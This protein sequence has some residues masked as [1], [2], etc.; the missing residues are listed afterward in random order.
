MLSAIYDFVFNFNRILIFLVAYAA[1]CF[2]RNYQNNL[3][4]FPGEGEDPESITNSV[5]W[6]QLLNEN[7]NAVL[8]V[9]FYAKW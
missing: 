4:P 9:D 3:L 6:K 1:Y 2:Y 8:V 5:E 7:P